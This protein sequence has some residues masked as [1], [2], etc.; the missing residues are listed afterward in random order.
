MWH[1][2][3]AGETAKP[4]RAHPNRPYPKQH[5]SETKSGPTAA[6]PA[7]PE[8]DA[9]E[10]PTPPPALGRER[11]WSPRTRAGQSCLG[12]T[13]GRLAERGRPLPRQRPPDVCKTTDRSLTR[14]RPLPERE[15]RTSRHQQ[16]RCTACGLAVPRPTLSSDDGRRLSSPPGA[17]PVCVAAH[18]C[19]AKRGHRHEEASRAGKPVGGRSADVLAATHRRRQRRPRGAE[20]FR[21]RATGYKF[22]ETM[23]KMARRSATPM[24]SPAIWR[25]GGLRA[26][27]L[28][29]TAPAR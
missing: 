11:G 8:P 6:V 23:I 2:H 25:P 21:R 29:P 20:H 4:K 3:L 12:P 15:T 10:S 7:K 14:R 17:R 13:T 16:S 9:W 19:P 28:R 1:A 24:T 27:R 18:E 22:P 26:W 5:V